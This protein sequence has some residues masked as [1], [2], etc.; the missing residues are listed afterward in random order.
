MSL[1][2][3]YMIGLSPEARARARARAVYCYSRRCCCCCAWLP[4]TGDGAAALSIGR[5]DDAG[6][7][8]CRVTCISE[9]SSRADRTLQR[10]CS[11]ST[12]N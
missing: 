8:N 11:T 3:E 12:N 10:Y 7:V 9:E 2:W 4:G 5:G 1:G 6:S